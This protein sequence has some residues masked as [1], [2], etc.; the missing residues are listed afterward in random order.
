MSIKDIAFIVEAGR[1]CGADARWTADMANVLGAALLGLC[2]AP[3]PDP[4]PAECFAIGADAVSQVLIE[5]DQRTE[6]LIE[7][8][9]QEFTDA[10]RN[11]F[12]KTGWLICENGVS[13]DTLTRGGRYVDLVVLPHRG[14][15]TR[16]LAEHVL[17]SG[18]PC[19]LLPERMSG[20]KP[21]ER[22]MIGWNGSRQAR[23]ALHAALPLMRQAKEV[24]LV[25]I[26][27]QTSP[28]PDFD[29]DW[30]ILAHLERHG[31]SAELHVVRRS[32]VDVGSALIDQATVFGAD[33]LILGAYGNSRAVEQIFGGVTRTVLDRGSVPLLV[34]H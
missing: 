5:M 30:G 31:V 19:M 25:V 9:R 10:I 7:A 3:V 26:G 6:S 14:A 20:W 4:T 17:L 16:R 13:L 24:R 32:P 8:S 12:G 28:A 18:A 22:V 33:L 11:R 2:H 1:P 21:F 27:S 29:K 23:S 15:V 34:A